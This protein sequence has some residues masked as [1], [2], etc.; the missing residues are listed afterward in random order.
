MS[1]PAFDAAGFVTFDLEKGSIRS[2]GDEPLTLLPVGLVSLLE[3]S[4]E[5][6]QSARAWGEVHGKRL[7]D[8]LGGSDEP[9]S[10]NLLADYLGGSLTVTGLGRIGI[11]IRGDALMFRIAAQDAPAGSAGRLALITGFL[12]GYLSALGPNEFAVLHVGHGADESSGPPRSRRWIM[13]SV[14]DRR[15]LLEKLLERVKNNREGLEQARQVEAA[16]PVE[17]EPVAPEPEPVAPEPE[18]V[19]PEPEP[20]APEPVVPE[21]VAEAAEPVADVEL[22]RPSEPPPIPQAA[23]DSSPAPPPQPEPAPGSEPVEEELR[24]EAKTAAS[25]AVAR[26]EGEPQRQWTLE[27]VLERAWKLGVGG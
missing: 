15:S 17:P 12:G 1:H 27:A 3:P 13:K 22:P 18:P 25:G 16:A 24:V 10:V 5:L 14:E 6:E 21:P 4:D 8:A 20:V 23:R 26:V 19:A 11:E 9:A 2:P 7:A